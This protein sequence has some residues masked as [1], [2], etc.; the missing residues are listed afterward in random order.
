LANG[1][2]PGVYSSGFPDTLVYVGHTLFGYPKSA[3]ARILRTEDEGVHWTDTLLKLSDNRYGLMNSFLPSPSDASDS[4]IYLGLSASHG[5]PVCVEQSLDAGAS[6]SPLGNCDFTS[7]HMIWDKQHPGWFW[8][9]GVVTVSPNV[10]AH[11]LYLS[12]D[13]GLTWTQVALPVAGPYGLLDAAS[14]GDG[15]IIYITS[16][17]GL[18]RSDD[19]GA[20]WQLLGKPPGALHPALAIDPT[21]PQILYLAG[22][23]DWQ[24]TSLGER[25]LFKSHDGGLTWSHADRGMLPGAIQTLAIEPKDPRVLYAGLNAGGLYRTRSGGE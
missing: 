7:L 9:I 8:A 6:F 10:T 22:Y 1:D 19:A 21:D 15:E 12:Q 16:D 17:Q 25:G 24:K 3:A 23:P 11:A 5:P 13:T 18:L 20:T 4:T 14:N 2:I